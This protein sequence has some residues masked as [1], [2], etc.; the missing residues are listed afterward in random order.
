MK[1][2]DELTR[3]GKLKRMRRLAENA[4]ANYDLV[5][6]RLRFFTIATNTMF[7]VDTAQGERLMLRIYTQEDS[8]LRENQAE[9]FW[10]DAILRDTDLRVTQPLPNRHG[11][12]ITLASAPGV[13][14]ERRCAL[15]RWVPGREL[16]Y[17]L[18]PLNYARL[19]RFMA[20]L[21]NHA[22][23]LNPPASLEPKR[24]DTVFYYPDEPV[25][26]NTP[27]YAH[28]FSPAVVRTL[29]AAIEHCNHFLEELHQDETNRIWIHGDM[30][31]W[32]VHVYRGE[33]YVIDFEDIM[34][35]YPL[36][37]I[38]V[39][40]YY[41]RTRPDYADLSQG[42]YDGYTSLRPWPVRAPGQ[43]ETL[44]TARRLNF[45]NY[46][47]WKEP[48]PQEFIEARRREVEEYLTNL[49]G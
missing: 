43:L 36:Q 14:G 5:I 24:W 38:A 30:H 35:G 17:H 10:L 12:Y 9:M 2:F 28:L 13:P 49:H 39:T 44:W 42:F 37:D 16:Y 48:E 33:L 19:G 4:L 22:Q 46:V 15:F 40:L 7:R 47:A 23:R 31:F 1:P 8:T 6:R 20:Q 27:A 41:G 32:N 29:D 45:I 3:C 34:F 21:H 18:S 26:Y 11:G 25:V